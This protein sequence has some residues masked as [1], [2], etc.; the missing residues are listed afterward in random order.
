[1]SF[2]LK[3][4]SV[5]PKHEYNQDYFVDFLATN[6]PDKKDVIRKFAGTVCVDHRALCIDLK[7]AM[8]LTSF[9]QRNAIWKEEAFKLAEASIMEVMEGT[10][11]SLQDIDQFITT[12]V[13][14]FSI[15]SL[16]ALLMNRMEFGPNTKRLPLFGFGCLGGV[17]SLNRAHDYL[18]T[19]TKGVVLITAVE[20]CSLT[21]QQEDLS[22]ANLVGTALFGDG[23]SSVLMVGKDHPM[24]K[25][26]KYEVVDYGA[27]FYKDSEDTMGWSIKDTG[28][29]LILNKNVAKIVNDNI[30]QNVDQLLSNNQLN[31]KDVKF[32][33]SH[34]GG[35]KVLI[36]MQE[37]LGL[38]KEHFQNSWDSL[39]DHGN[40]SSVSVLNVLQRSIEGHIGS[41]GEY[42]IMAAMGP[43]FNSEIT[44]IRKVK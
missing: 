13:T 38:R 44:L 11:L 6:W 15:P 42:G 41:R 18:K 29:K 33:I 10:G 36:A 2:I 21:F 8:Q 39:R 32:S 25:N 34:P 20:L 19:N 17:A 23:S 30:P 14:G 28:F 12:S 43:G 31:L 5:F 7:E 26:S 1:M 24:A 35:P 16:D 3:S 40:L 37:A 9:A 4:K 22:V 27:F